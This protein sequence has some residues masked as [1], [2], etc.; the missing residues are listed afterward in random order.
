LLPLAR[1]L[2]AWRADDGLE[3]SPREF[4]PRI[5]EFFQQ[6]RDEAIA[7]GALAGAGVAVAA[8]GGDGS[9]SEPSGPVTRSFNSAD[10]PKPILDHTTVSSSLNVSGMNGTI[11]SLSVSVNISHTY[12]GDLTVSLRHP[13]GTA[14][15]L[16]D[17]TGSSTDNIV[18]TYRPTDFHGRSANGMWILGVQD[19]ASV[20]QGQLNSWSLT[21][22]VS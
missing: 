14:T 22:T 12:Q 19:S 4:P 6:A 7:S 13:D 10:V 3:L 8:G 5:L 2:E 1:F 11:S 20:D 9:Q 21:I 16:H 17:R 18:T 15:T